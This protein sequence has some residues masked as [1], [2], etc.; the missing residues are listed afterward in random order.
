[1]EAKP[2]QE[3]HH[4]IFL[5][6]PLQG[7]INPFIQLALR[8]ASR[9]FTITF[10]EL[11]FVHQ[12][13]TQARLATGAESGDIFEGARTG[14]D[15]LDIR[16]RV[17]SDGL[18]LDFDRT[19]R[20]DEYLEWYLYG[21]MYGKLEEAI[22]EVMSDSKSRPNVLVAD[23]FFP[24]ASKIARHFGLK[25]ASFWT[26]LALVFTF[27][28][29][30]HLLRQHGHFDCPGKLYSPPLSL[31]WTIYPPL[32]IGIFRWTGK[33]YTSFATYYTF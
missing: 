1:M 33:L 17:V 28:Y 5:S 25:Y 6:L 27:Y 9:G 21:G 18:P 23:T 30:V 13:L 4:A 2:P 8:L 26:E 10:L 7:H 14:P 24:W 15:T 11:E 31:A 20:L 29:H 12:E 22:E 3:N 19:G 32:P 16:Y